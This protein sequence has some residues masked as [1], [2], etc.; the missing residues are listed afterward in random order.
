MEVVRRSNMELL[1]IVA[2]LLV[3]I[4]HASF[5][6]FGKPT[7]GYCHKDGA[8]SFAVFFFESMS[9]VCVN[10]FVLLSGW[11][12]IKLKLK[13]IAEMLF[14]VFFF[15]FLILTAL[16]VVNPEEYLHL[17]Y[18]STLLMLNEND[19]WFIKSYIGLCIFAPFLNAFI[20]RSNEKGLRSILIVFYIFQTVYGWLSINGAGWLGG[21][22]SAVSFMGLYLLARYVRLYG[23]KIISLSG[24]FHISVYVG[25]MF[26]QAVLAWL[27]TYIGLPVAGR[28]FTY[29]N[30]LVIVQAL[31]MLLFFNKLSF[32]SKFINR[33]AISCVAVYLLHA[34]ELVLRTYYGPTIKYIHDSYGM[35]VSLLAIPAFMLAIFFVAI[36]LDKVRMAIWS[37]TR[38]IKEWEIN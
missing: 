26:F 30:P 38:N 27:V 22:Y 7:T 33:I 18:F 1:R 31:A 25:I 9:V 36:L 12:G 29:T 3:M 24:K 16:I 8:G 37:V 15:A 32:Q 23:N 2:M 28:L 21:G 14:Q 10:L 13:K 6:A 20:E 5:L 34:N 35:P 17:K 4:V 19:Y 11:F